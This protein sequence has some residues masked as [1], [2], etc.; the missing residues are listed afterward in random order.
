MSLTATDK[1]KHDV[2]YISQLSSIANVVP[3][4]AKSDL[5]TPGQIDEVRAAIPSDT[6]SVPRLPMSFDAQASIATATA[7]YSVSCVNGPDYDTMD[8]SLLMGSE[9][10]QPLLPSEL[11]SLIDQILDSETAMYLRHLA[12]RKLTSW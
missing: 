12:A 2:D 8:A 4:I 5:L 1:L 3:L 11:H 9:Y 7:P 10:V 6:S